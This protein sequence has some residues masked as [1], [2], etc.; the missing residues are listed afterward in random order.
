MAPITH[1]RIIGI[2]LITLDKSVLELAPDME[3]CLDIW[4]LP[5]G[6]GKDDRVIGMGS[7]I[8]LDDPNFRR[9]G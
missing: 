7:P 2:H 8:E 9:V 6:N 5:N 1:H 4:K 3:W